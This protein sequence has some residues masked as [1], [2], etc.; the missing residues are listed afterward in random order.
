MELPSEPELRLNVY[1][2]DPE[3]PTADGPKLLASWSA[4]QHVNAAERGRD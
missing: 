1:T 4:T 3:T 2:A